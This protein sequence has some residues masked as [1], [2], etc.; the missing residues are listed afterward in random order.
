MNDALDR[1]ASAVYRV[2]DDVT[3]ML[4]TT[5]FGAWR[6]GELAHSRI[7][8]QQKALFVQVVEIVFGLLD[9]K[10]LE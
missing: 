10:L 8:S 6:V 1:N 7:F 9:A 4:E 3:L 2:E 5:P